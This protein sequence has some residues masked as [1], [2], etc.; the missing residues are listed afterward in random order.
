MS[1]KVVEF[2]EFFV[3]NSFIYLGSKTFFVVIAYPN[4]SLSGI[5]NTLLSDPFYLGR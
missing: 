2:V 3:S 1:Q 4:C 5:W